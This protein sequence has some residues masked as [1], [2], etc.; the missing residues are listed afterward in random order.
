RD[1]AA[2]IF[3]D[4]SLPPIGTRIGRYALKRVIAW[5]GMGPVFEAVQDEPRR[6]VALKTLR[7]GL[8]SPERLQ[9]FRFEA[10][11]LGSLRH[12]SIAQV[13]EAGTH[14][15][16]GEHGPFIAMGVVPGA[17]GLL[18]YAREEDLELPARLA[19]F[20][21]VGEAVQHGHQ[22][23]V[24]HRDLKPGNIL[25][26]A[27]GRA[28]VIDFG[29]ARATAR[30]SPFDGVATQTGQILGTLAYMAPEQLGGSPDSVDV[31]SDVY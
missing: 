23:G 21:E 7:F 5:G 13:F 17:R 26:D 19:L 10:E 22:K 12:P 3:G 4:T 30:A 16:A 6:A 24:I 29:V 11:I 28:K 1:S 8:T 20:L 31:R 15:E 27:E 9:R 18:S 2:P 25:V 14:E